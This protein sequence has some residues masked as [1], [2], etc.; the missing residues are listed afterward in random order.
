MANVKPVR[1][2]KRC[3]YSDLPDPLPKYCMECGTPI[4]ARAS[5]LFNE[6]SYL[7]SQR[8]ALIAKLGEGR[9]GPGDPQF[10]EPLLQIGRD[11]VR[12]AREA[13]YRHQ[14]DCMLDSKIYLE[15]V[16]HSALARPEVAELVKLG[17]AIGNISAAISEYLKSGGKHSD[18]QIGQLP[19]TARGGGGD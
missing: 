17:Q 12:F 11:M 18:R 10:D 5:A 14:L 19:P 4:E 7:S 2:C 16:L 1:I 3:G 15:N 8:D 13:P 9:L 6:P